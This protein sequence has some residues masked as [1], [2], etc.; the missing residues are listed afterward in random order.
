MNKS[1][2]FL[3]RDLPSTYHTRYKEN[4][5]TFKNKGTAL[6]NF[7]P[8]SGLRKFR[9]SISIVEA[10]Y[11]LSSKKV[12]AQSVVNWTVVGQIS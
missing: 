5:G 6:W 2:W 10:C 7:A 4:S 12:D 1:G 9:H 11:Q 3:A 8:K